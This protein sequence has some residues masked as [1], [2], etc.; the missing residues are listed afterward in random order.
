MVF[1][2]TAIQQ[3]RQILPNDLTDWVSC[4]SIFCS[5][6]STR[7]TRTIQVQDQLPDD[8]TEKTGAT[9]TASHSAIVTASV[10]IR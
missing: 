6:Q 3:F 8:T 9:S 7:N 5:S 1:H 2:G 4:M 10:I